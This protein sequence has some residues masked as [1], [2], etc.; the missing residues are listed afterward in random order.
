MPEPPVLR[1]DDLRRAL[2]RALAIERQR[3]DALALASARGWTVVD[4]YEDASI[5]AHDK[6]KRRP[7]YE[8]MVADYEVGRFDAIVCYDLDRL[9]RQPRQLED[10][11]DAAEERGLALITLNGQADLST[12]AGRM[13]ARIK[14][15]VSRQE[16][17]RKAAR[18]KRAMTQRVQMGK[19]PAGVRL[20]G[21]LSN[22]DLH[23]VEAPIVRSVFERFM[24]GSPSSPLRLGF[25]RLARRRAPVVPGTRQ[26]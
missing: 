9:S 8:Q 5:S 23:P 19:V 18:Q 25:S 2:N 24:A 21:Y 4:V 11:I 3:E 22:G 13:F 12:D 20:T 7:A 10:W 6:R 1:I 15:A 14:A 26:A 17:E 16:S